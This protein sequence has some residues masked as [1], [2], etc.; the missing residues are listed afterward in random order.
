MEKKSGRQDYALITAAGLSSRMKQFKP[1]MTVNGLTL[2]EHV[3]RRFRA[4]GI[5]QIVMVTGY[6]GDVLETALRS[7]GILFC[8][9]A[10][11]LSSRMFGSV[12]CGLRKILQSGVPCDRVLFCPVD[13]PFF[14]VETV[15]TLLQHREPL[16]IPAYREKCGHPIMMDHTLLPDILRH[17]GTE[18]L[19]GALRD[20][21]IVPARVAVEDPGILRDADTP[22]DFSALKN[23]YERRCFSGMPAEKNEYERIC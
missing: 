9:N 2:A 22:E 1:L 17:D 3:I 8:R 11:Y 18:G 19:K 14:Q 23:L 7:E 12:A 13:V 6:R 20:S 21:G 15:R 10:D 5:R 4:S 16:V